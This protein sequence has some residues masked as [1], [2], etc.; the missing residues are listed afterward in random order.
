M[1]GDTQLESSLADK[2]LG[3]LVNTRLNMSR[4]CALAAKAA[5]DTLGCIRQSN[6]S[7]SREVIL[8]LYSALVRPRLQLCV[9]LWAPQYKRDVDRLE[10][11]EQRATKMIKG[12][13]QLTYEERLRELGLFI[14]EKR[15]LRADLINVYKYLKG[16]CK[17]D[18][19]RLFLLVPSDRTRGNRHKLKHRRCCLKIRV[20]KRWHRLLRKVVESPSL[21][22]FKSHLDMVLGNWL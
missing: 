4:Q 17:G 15:G 9:Q 10:T 8:P 5:N 1:L 11:V 2:D 21:E 22:V 7:R 16:G 19:A 18:G 6:A 14:L 13:Q 20:T 12:L 3:V